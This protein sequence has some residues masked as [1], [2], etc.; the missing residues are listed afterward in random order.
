MVLGS[1]VICPLLGSKIALKWGKYP[2][3]LR[4][5]LAIRMPEPE[6]HFSFIAIYLSTYTSIQSSIYPPTHPPFHPCICPLIHPWNLSIP[7]KST[8]L[9]PEHQFLDLFSPVNQ[10]RALKM[11]TLKA[12]PLSSR[13]K[14][15]VR[16]Q[17]RRRPFYPSH[18]FAFPYSCRVLVNR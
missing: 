11:H 3:G 18:S 13:E 8:H 10:F 17:G 14:V 2:K 4:S 16:S 5:Q 6:K 15:S 7:F 12:N 1:H 9:L